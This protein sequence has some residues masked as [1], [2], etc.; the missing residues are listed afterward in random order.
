MATYRLEPVDHLPRFGDGIW[1]ETEMR[2]KE[3]GLDPTWQF[4]EK[5]TPMYQ[6]EHNRFHVDAPLPTV[7]QGVDTGG[8]SIPFYPAFESKLLAVEGSFEIRQDANGGI[9]RVR[10]D[11]TH[12]WMPTFLKSCVESRDDWQHVKRRLDPTTPQRWEGFEEHATQSAKKVKSGAAILYGGGMGGYMYLRNL[13]GPVNLL[14]V[15]HDDPALIHECMTTWRDF[16]LTCWKRVQ[17]HMPF[18][19]INLAEDMCYKTGPLI[20]PMMVREFLAPYYREC[21]EE[22]RAAQNERLWIQIDTDGFHDPLLAVYEEIGVNAL[23]PFEVAAGCDVIRTA[24]E[25]P[26]LV[27]QGGIDKRALAEGP[28][29]IDR[30]LE[31][32]IPAMVERGGYIPTVD[33]WVPHDVALHHYQH[34]RNRIVELDH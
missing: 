18:M 15:F 33:H 32:I 22:L 16:M 6:C 1:I 19:V 24:R 2:W 8:L 5:G 3:E 31:R 25:Y 4:N 9:K 20:S 34:Y 27:I 11:G 7:G 17:T 10:V 12:G 29:A 21:I 26:H 28:E 23:W 13:F 14:Y 30:E